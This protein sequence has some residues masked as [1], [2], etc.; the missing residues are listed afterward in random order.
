MADL[1][2][3][4]ASPILAVEKRSL[5]G[6]HNP[7]DEAR[8]G[9]CWLL[10]GGR[11]SQDPST[12]VRLVEQRDVWRTLFSNAGRPGSHTQG[13]FSETNTGLSDDGSAWACVPGGQTKG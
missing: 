8:H 10:G 13:S 5:Q 6:A 7:Q 4:G 11:H 2:Q 3:S 12:L 9:V 1:G